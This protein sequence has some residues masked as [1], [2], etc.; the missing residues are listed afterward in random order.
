MLKSAQCHNAIAGFG[1]RQDSIEQEQPVFLLVVAAQ[2]PSVIALSCQEI[3]RG[4]IDVSVE[5]VFEISGQ[6]VHFFT[7]EHSPMSMRIASVTLDKA[8]LS[9][10]IQSEIQGT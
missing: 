6:P 4:E 9:I 2:A 8:V 10:H 3:G 7:A 5:T 1:S